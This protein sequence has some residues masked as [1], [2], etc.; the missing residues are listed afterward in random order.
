MST[1]GFGGR[2]LGI[3]FLATSYTVPDGMFTMDDT[4]NMIC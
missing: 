1:S 2:H 3:G 4:E